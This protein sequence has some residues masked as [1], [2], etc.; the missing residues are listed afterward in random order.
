MANANGVDIPTESELEGSSDL[1]TLKLTENGKIAQL[2][3]S[4]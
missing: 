2:Q 1:D 3:N 4:P